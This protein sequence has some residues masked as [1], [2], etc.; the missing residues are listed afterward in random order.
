MPIFSRKEETTEIHVSEKHVGLR[1]FCFVLALLVAVGAFAFGVTRI[2]YKD[3]GMHDLTAAAD[4]ELPLY[5][6]GVH[7]TIRFRGSSNEIKLALAAADKVYTEALK[8]AIKLLDAETEYAGTVNLATL[9]ARPNQDV[10]LSPELYAVLTDAWAKTREQ[11]GY[12]LFAGPLQAEWQSILVLTEPE[13]FDPLRNEDEAA[14][15]ETIARWTGDLSQLRLVTVDAENCVVRLEAPEEYLAFLEE[16][17]LKPTVADLNLLRDAYLLELIAPALEEAGLSDG[18]LSSDSGLNL[19]LSGLDA[20]QFGLYG[21][22]EGSPLLAASAAVTPGSACS[23]LTAFSLSAGVN[24]YYSLEE[25]GQVHLR[26]PQLPADGRDRELLLS[27]CVLRRDGKLAD[28]CY[29]NLCLWAANSAQELEE[30][31]RESESAIAWMLR[32]EDGIVLLNPA[33]KDGFVPEEGFE[34]RQTE[35]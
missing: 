7:A 16:Y 33:A 22:R 29:E 9:N 18:Y 31:A 30:L 5:S 2:G 15:L 6:S 12:S 20:G 34:S 24:M 35:P 19:A 27:S 23:T 17:E 21:F 32:G 1:V 13:D 3:E 11:R 14:R 25:Q 10:Q 4:K 28:A 8:Q 26:N